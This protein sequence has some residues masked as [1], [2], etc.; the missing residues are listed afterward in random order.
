MLLRASG[1]SRNEAYDL[2]AVM[3]PG[4]STGIA[5]DRVLIELVD[6]TLGTDEAR[7]ANAREA[8]VRDLGPAALIDTAAIIGSFTQAVRTA[9]G[10]GIPLDEPLEMMTRDLRAELGVTRFASAANTP[11]A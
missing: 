7:R 11:G 1:A 3:Q 8:L 6:A 4:T 9:D 5:D 10:A 2:T